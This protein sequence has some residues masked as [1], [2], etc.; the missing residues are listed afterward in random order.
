MYRFP[1]RMTSLI[2]ALIVS[3]VILL[4]P[5]FLID[6]QG[7]SQHTLLMIFLFATMLGFI[8]GVGFRPQ[9]TL[10][11]LVLSPLISWPVMLTAIVLA[12]YHTPLS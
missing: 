4:Y 10:W 3:V 9:T 11:Q 2:L 7:K 8:H 5:Q 1:A 12:V 6:D